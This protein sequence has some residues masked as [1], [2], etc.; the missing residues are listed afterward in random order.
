MIEDQ[1]RRKLGLVRHRGRMS[2]LNLESAKANHRNQCINVFA[3]RLDGD[4]T[5][6][7]S[8]TPAQVFGIAAHSCSM[9]SISMIRFSEQHSQTWTCCR[10]GTRVLSGGG[11]LVI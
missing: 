8:N 9:Y 2:I 7:L 11:R 1:M 5:I 4:A 6:R 10:R 3:R